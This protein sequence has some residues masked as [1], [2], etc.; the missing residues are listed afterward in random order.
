MFLRTTPPPPPI[1]P[2]HAHH[3]GIIFLLPPVDRVRHLR[4]QMISLV[5]QILDRRAQRLDG[6]TLG[7]SRLYFK[8]YLMHQRVRVLVACEFD[9]GIPEELHPQEIPHGVIFLIERECAGVRHL[10]VRGVFDFLLVVIKNE[11]R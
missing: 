9:G 10:R 11:R 2:L 5:T 7:A 6:E 1:G 8:K 4:N 3:S